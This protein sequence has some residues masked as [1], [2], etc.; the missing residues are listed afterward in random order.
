MSGTGCFQHKEADNGTEVQ[1]LV[2]RI[3]QELTDPDADRCPLVTGEVCHLQFFKS[4][5]GPATVHFYQQG[6]V[7]IGAITVNVQ[8]KLQ[9]PGFHAEQFAGFAIFGQDGK[10]AEFAGPNINNCAPFR[11]ICRDLLE[12]ESIIDTRVGAN[13][14]VPL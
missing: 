11:I 10:V 4:K 13:D 2:P 7:R 14:Q 1:R 8:I 3:L 12:Q 6:A 9:F 5:G